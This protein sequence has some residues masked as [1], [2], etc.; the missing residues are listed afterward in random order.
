MCPAGVTVASLD[1]TPESL[2]RFIANHLSS[3]G[4][5]GF[6]ELFISEVILK[7]QRQTFALK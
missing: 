6:H 7:L 1:Y 4:L 3:H 2:R 5:A